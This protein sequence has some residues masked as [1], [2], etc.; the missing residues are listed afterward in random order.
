MLRNISSL[1]GMEWLPPLLLIL[2]LRLLRLQEQIQGFVSAS[3]E[4]D[5]IKFQNDEV[6]LG[7]LDSIWSVCVT[8]II[9]LFKSMLRYPPFKILVT[10]GTTGPLTKLKRKWIGWI[11]LPRTRRLQERIPFRNSLCIIQELLPLNPRL[12]SDISSVIRYSNAASAPLESNVTSNPL[13]ATSFAPQIGLNE[14][15]C[16]RNRRNLNAHTFS[17]RKKA[18]RI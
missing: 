8:T 9:E 2:F 12:G 1:W 17:L 3:H 6:I 10:V 14:K 16:T 11:R 4:Y 7:L 5:L 15:S 13:W 18:M